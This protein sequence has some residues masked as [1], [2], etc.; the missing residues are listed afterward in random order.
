MGL[1]ALSIKIDKST[2]ELVAII[3]IS[4]IEVYENVGS[5]AQ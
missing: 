5:P 3:S 2:S 4:L 1:A